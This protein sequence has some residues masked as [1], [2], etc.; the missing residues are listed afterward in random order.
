MNLSSISKK[1]K[2]CMLVLCLSYL[3]V[4]VFAWGITGH[5]VVGQVADY[6]LSKKAR[7]AIKEILGG[8]NI[9]MASNWGDFIKS[10]TAFNYLSSWHYVNIPAGLDQQGVFSFL[11]GDKL[12]NVYNKIPEMISILKNKQS[13]PE[14]K[15]MALRLLVHFVGDVH[16]PMHI[17]KK[18][19]LG[20]NK[21]LVTWFGE[22]SNLHRIWDE[23]LVENQHLSYTEYAA[24]I[25]HPTKEQIKNW[26][27]TS[28]KGD[29]FESYLICNKIYMETKPDERLGYKYNFDFVDTVNEQLLKGGIRLAAMI[30]DIY[31]K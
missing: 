31:A 18:E 27:T 7:K 25:N 29:V 14:Q 15:K 8:E 23:A 24:A 6:Y 21:V 16:Q 17:G 22:K 19:D 12:P 10:D 30:N 26:S 2:V 20:G 11:D 5:R 4:Q 13:T 3:P 28:L 9:A 1:V